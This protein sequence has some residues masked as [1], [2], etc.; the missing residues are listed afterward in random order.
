M[1]LKLIVAAVLSLS[2]VA[3]SAASVDL[4]TL[5]G[6]GFD[7]TGGFSGKFALGAAINDAWSFTLETA[8]NV[9]FGA[10]Q[11]FSFGSGITSFAGVLA[12]YGPLTLTVNP[13]NTQANLNWSGLL[14]A[15]TYTV[16]LSGISGA[17]NTTYVT[18][19]AA[20]PVPEPESYALLMAGLG[21]LAFVARRR[22][23]V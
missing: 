20:T 7:S 23:S 17:R 19:V 3:A 8:S 4:G 10:Q 9:S 1:K 6:T 12:G 11:S 13:A 18:T 21:V 14:A 5:D 16:N 15:G 2:A 22:K